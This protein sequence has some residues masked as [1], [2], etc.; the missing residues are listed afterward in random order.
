MKRLDDYVCDN[1]GLIT[2]DHWWKC[3]FCGRIGEK[4]SPKPKEEIP[5]LKNVI[6]KFKWA[7]AESEGEE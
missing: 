4:E 5:V 2:Y 1:C 7:D 6:I 3:P